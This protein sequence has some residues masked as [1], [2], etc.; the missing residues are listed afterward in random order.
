[1]SVFPRS[2]RLL[3]IFAFLAGSVATP[4]LVPAPSEASPATRAVLIF[5]KNFQRP[6]HSTIT[7]RLW[8]RTSKGWRIVE[9]K[10]WRAGSGLG[11][12]VP[13]ARNAC[14][15]DRGWLPNGRYAVMQKNDHGG[16]YIKGRV[17]YLGDMPCRNGNVRRMLFIHSETGRNNVPC[18]DAP[19]DQGCRWEYPRINDY[20]SNGCIKMAPQDLAE[21][22]RLYQRHFRSGV[23]Y[24]TDAVRL[25]VIS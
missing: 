11:R 19:G 7:W 9:Q 6:L 21:L 23:R 3:A 1:M 20:R 8:Q 2:V 16:D 24:P 15:K 4:V 25:R 10:S 22:T 18:P 13:G 17:F 5:D 14:V 12:R